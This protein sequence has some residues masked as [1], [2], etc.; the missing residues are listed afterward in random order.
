MLSVGIGKL[1]F[2]RLLFLVKQTGITDDILEI[3]IS[4]GLEQMI[5]LGFFM[6]MF[7]II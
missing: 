6:M 2:D 1:Y 7:I 3:R 4:L 5:S